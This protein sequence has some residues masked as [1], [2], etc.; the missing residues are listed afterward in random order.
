M[1]QELIG[2]RIENLE[3]NLQR[4]KKLV[5]TSKKS[6]QVSLKGMLKGM[7]TTEDEIKNAKMSLFNI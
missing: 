7:K 5:I 4:L 2:K 6:D 1:E 3:N